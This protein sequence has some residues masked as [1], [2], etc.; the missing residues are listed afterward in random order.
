MF[1]RCKV[2]IQK[3]MRVDYNQIVGMHRGA[4]AGFLV[5]QPR[6]RMHRGASLP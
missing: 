1:L 3:S 2:T 4:S 6:F 5:N